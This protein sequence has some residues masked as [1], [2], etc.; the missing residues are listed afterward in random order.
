MKNKKTDAGNI[1]H[2]HKYLRSINKDSLSVSNFNE[3]KSDKQQEQYYKAKDAKLKW[4]NLST[5]NRMPFNFNKVRV[6]V[7]LEG[8][9]GL[10]D[11]E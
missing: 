1:R 6:S 9:G 5:I 10:K 8:K 11:N 2:K 7:Q 3:I 4:V